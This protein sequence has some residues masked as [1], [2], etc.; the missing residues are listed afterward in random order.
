MGKDAGNVAKLAAI[1]GAAYLTGGGS[2]AAGAGAGAAEGAMGAG[3][4]G[5]GLGA[6]GSAEGLAGTAGLLGSGLDLAGM[7][8]AGASA[9]PTL[10]GGFTPSYALGTGAASSA[11]SA[12]PVAKGASGLF[13]KA[14]DNPAQ[15]AMSGANMMNQQN[16]PRP[17][18]AAPARMMMPMQQAPAQQNAQLSPYRLPGGLSLHSMNTAGIF[19]GGRYG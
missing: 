11:A 7:S 2:L 1:A 6:A 15:L 3:A 17:T 8:A 19:G 4:L 13:S 10:A 14:F 16:Q 18:Q 5:A 9:A 12:A